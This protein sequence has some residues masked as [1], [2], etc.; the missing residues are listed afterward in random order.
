MR[1]DVNYESCDWSTAVSRHGPP[2]LARFIAAPS[3]SSTLQ[4]TRQCR[5]ARRQHS[6]LHRHHG[7]PTPARRRC[8][9]LPPPRSPSNGHPTLRNRRTP[10]ALHWLQSA[11]STRQSRP[12]HPD[13]TC[14]LSVTRHEDFR[15]LHRP[16]QGWPECDRE[17]CS[18][19]LLHR[20]S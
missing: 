3:L 20:D 14:T 12:S 1:I 13:I 5:S 19:V 16:I 2:A 8:F 18:Y 15:G 7:T 9:C 6:F 4:T 11:S 17:S 10:L